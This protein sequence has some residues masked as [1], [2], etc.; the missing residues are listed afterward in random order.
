[1]HK[2]SLR[3]WAYVQAPAT[4][5]YVYTFTLASTSAAGGVQGQ[6]IGLQL[7]PSSSSIISVWD[8]RSRL[9]NRQPMS[10]PLYNTRRPRVRQSDWQDTEEE[11]SHCLVCCCELT[12]TDCPWCIT[13]TD[14]VLRTT[15]DFSVFHS[16]Q[17]I[18]AAPLWPQAVMFARTYFLTYLIRYDAL[19]VDSIALLR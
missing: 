10:P 3:E 9:S 8:V 12:S 14:S 2:R 6:F 17:D 5:V 4:H 7:P 15:E 18:I 16:L 19:I 1:M 13:D 11:V